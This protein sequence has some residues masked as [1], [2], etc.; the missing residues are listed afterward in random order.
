M[1]LQ[2]LEFAR[3][4]ERDMRLRVANPARG[5]QWTKSWPKYWGQVLVQVGKRNQSEALEALGAQDFR[6]RWKLISIDFRQKKRKTA[7]IICSE[8]ML[9]ICGHW[10]SAS[11]S[12]KTLFSPITLYSALVTSEIA[13]GDHNM[14]SYKMTVRVPLHDTL[15]CNCQ[16]SFQIRGFCSKDKRWAEE[17]N[18]P[19]GNLYLKGDGMSEV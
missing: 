5:D 9:K 14:F 3:E 4:E 18:I 13:L 1:A 8:V 2:W 10:R 12:T 19:G 6:W 11:S 16:G 15:L 17:L 7:Y